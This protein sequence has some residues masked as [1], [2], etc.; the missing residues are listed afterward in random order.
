MMEDFD[1]SGVNTNEEGGKSKKLTSPLKIKTILFQN[2]MRKKNKKL[3]DKEFNADNNRLV[4]QINN[5]DLQIF[6]I[7]EELK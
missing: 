6:Y 4:F 5:F 1:P 7:K 3:V 2:S